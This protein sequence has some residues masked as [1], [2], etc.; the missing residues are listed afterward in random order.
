MN[1]FSEILNGLLRSEAWHP[2]HL[3]IAVAV[4]GLVLLNLT[5]PAT[6][7]YELIPVDN[8]MRMYLLDTKTGRVWRS[9]LGDDDSFRKM[10]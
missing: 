7:R 1:K 6:G 8:G 10:H 3:A 5:Q 4:V 2:A 9:W